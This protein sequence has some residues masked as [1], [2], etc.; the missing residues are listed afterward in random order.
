MVN[1]GKYTIH[2][3]YGVCFQLTTDYKKTWRFLVIQ[4]LPCQIA[5]VRLPV[6]VAKPRNTSTLGRGKTGAKS[7]KET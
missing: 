5:H 2:G 1:T 7:C 3:S 6:L 4:H